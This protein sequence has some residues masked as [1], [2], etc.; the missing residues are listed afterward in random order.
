MRLRGGC[1][2][3]CCVDC[4]VHPGPVLLCKRSALT[5]SCSPCQELCSAR[6]GDAHRCGR[7]WLVPPPPPP[8]RSRHSS[9]RS[10][11]CDSAR[12]L[13]Y[14][15]ASAVPS[16]PLPWSLPLLPCSSDA[17]TCPRAD[18]FCVCA[19]SHRWRRCS[20]DQRERP[21]KPAPPGLFCGAACP[22]CGL[23]A[24][25][26]V[27]GATGK[28]GSAACGLRGHP[29]WGWPRTLTHPHAALRGRPHFPYLLG[30]V[31]F[32]GC[33]CGVGLLH[34]VCVGSGVSM[35]VV[36]CQDDSLC[37]FFLL[38]FHPF[39]LWSPTAVPHPTGLSSSLL[40]VAAPLLPSLPL[41]VLYCDVWA[42]PV[43]IL[44]RALHAP[45]VVYARGT[46]TWVEA[47]L[48]RR[49]RTPPSRTVP[50]AH[51]SCDCCS[52]G[53]VETL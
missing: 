10:S 34:C 32:G 36:S 9:P 14:V 41:L 53:Q 38:L 12:T 48:L 35:W 20:L 3:I 24:R 45:C 26:T 44:R 31:L 21:C 29:G 33:L 50:V 1:P 27:A 19:H 16:P 18:A 4:G 49:T 15:Y 7:L 52:V 37:F 46:V 40:C 23:F 47:A 2:G 5:L 28:R 42:T 30:V 39:A 8:F 25:G 6:L 13:S 17:H 11:Q 43:T 22:V 51:S